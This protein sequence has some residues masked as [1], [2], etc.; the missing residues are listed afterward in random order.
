MQTTARTT[1]N[2]AG[3]RERVRVLLVPADPAAPVEVIS[4]ANSA[5]AISDA[6]GGHLLDDTTIGQLPDGSWFTFYLADASGLALPADGNVPALPADA[7]GLA[8]PDNLRAAALAAR[9]GLVDRG[10]QAQIAGPVLLAGIE[11]RSGADIDVPRQVLTA[12]QD[13]SKVV[14]VSRW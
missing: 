3:Q 13:T 4:V 10:L 7:S 14:G 9:L 6:I 12:A 1:T 8:L 11:P 5:R 2:Q